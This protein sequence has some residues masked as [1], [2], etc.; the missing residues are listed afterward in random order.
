VGLVFEKKVGDAVRAGERVC[1]LYSND[2]SRVPGALAM[3]RKAI[4][5]SPH[6]VSPP[7]AVLERILGY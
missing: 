4:A 3:I 6:R 5:I 2:R 7:P 1:I